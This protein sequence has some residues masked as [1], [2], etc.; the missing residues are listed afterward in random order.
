MRA[1]VYGGGVGAG[2]GGRDDEGD[3]AG[4]GLRCKSSEERG[5]LFVLAY[6]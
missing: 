1:E 6:D 3:G 4:M 2:V 5:M